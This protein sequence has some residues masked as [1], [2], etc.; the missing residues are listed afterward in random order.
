MRNSFIER[1]G[2]WVVGQS[3]LMSAVVVLAVALPGDC[4]HLDLAI[5]GAT[6]LVIG[7]VF[8]IAGVAALKSNR[9]P[10]PMPRHDS[11]LVQSGIYS[12][13]RHPLY[14]SVILCSLGWA[15]IWQSW[16]A[17]VAAVALIPF[18][19]AKTRREEHWLR[20]K[21]PGYAD[22]EKQ[23]KRFVPWIY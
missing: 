15:L 23:V 1:G 9:T 7:G 12:R 6:L 3:L 14:T 8:G 13:V 20:E 2:G 22:Y 11:Q 21:F 4:T 18:F 19:A 16:P 17:L 5:A 10:F